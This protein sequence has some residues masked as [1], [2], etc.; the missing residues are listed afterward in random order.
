[1][2]S[3]CAEQ[4]LK[5]KRQDLLSAKKMLREYSG[6]MPAILLLL[7]RRH[8][9]GSNE[10]HSSFLQMLQSVCKEGNDISHSHRTTKVCAWLLVPTTYLELFPHREGLHQPQPEPED[11]GHR[12]PE[13][14]PIFQHC[15]E[16]AK[17]H[18]HIP[19]LL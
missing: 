3:S 16:A 4:V 18:P 7:H 19:V 2:L 6:Q 14:A 11:E 8:E 9:N 17:T 10:Q 12:V 13:A 5:W 15:V 1:M